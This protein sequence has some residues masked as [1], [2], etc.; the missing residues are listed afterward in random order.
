MKKED[1]VREALSSSDQGDGKEIVEELLDEP[2]I[3]QSSDGYHIRNDPDSQA[4]AASRVVETCG[5]TELQAEAT[6]SR[7]EQAGG[8]DN[9]DKDAVLDSL[10]DW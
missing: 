2:Y 3:Y 7:F 4:Q 9:Y 8:F 6:F 10:D 1:L 5:Y